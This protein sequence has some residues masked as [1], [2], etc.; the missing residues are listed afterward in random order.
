MKIKKTVLF[1]LT[2][3]MFIFFSASVQ[4]DDKG[5]FTDVKESD[6]F[7]GNVSTLYKLS[8]INGKP[9]KDGTVIFDPRGLVT[10]AEFTKMLVEAMEYDLIDGSSFFDIGYDRHWA[11]KYIETAVKEGVI[12]PEKEGE[13]YWLDIPIKRNDMAYMIFKAL[14]LEPSNN[15]SP[16]PDADMP[17]ATKLYEEFLING[18]PEGN[19]VYFK[20]SGLTIRAEAAA[21]IA[22]MVE[23]RENPA[24]YKEKKLWDTV[25]EYGVPMRLYLMD[26]KGKT[27]E[28]RRK[29][30]DEQLNRPAP[31][32]KNYSDKWF[33]RT[34]EKLAY[35][36]YD[37]AKKYMAVEYNIDYMTVD[38]S[39]EENIKDLISKNEW[40]YFNPYIKNFK[41]RKIVMES[42]FYT[43][44]DLLYYK[45]V[46]N[47]DDLGIGDFLRGT[48]KFKYSEPTLK[49]YLEKTKDVNGNPL[50]TGQWYEQD[51]DVQ[52]GLDAARVAHVVVYDVY[53]ISQPKPI[54]SR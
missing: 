42:K 30:L 47:G 11:K 6:W 39:Y 9:Q 20:P 29:D 33:K 38:Q 3:A 31:G 40:Q 41:D 5:V 28:K 52:V 16:F 14:K 26:V 12:D 36:M 4:A 19:K 46:E 48:L 24:A 45:G 27:L 49:S 1:T 35:D 51:V 22:R 53:K 43:A 23:Y 25:T 44:E 54:E 13:D 2:I 32:W 37:T 34:P 50:K 21:I 10:K 18:S 8:I 7:A 17:Y 15:K